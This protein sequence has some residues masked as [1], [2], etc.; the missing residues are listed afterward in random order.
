MRRRNRKN[1]RRGNVVIPD[2]LTGIRDRADH[3]SS[4]HR[5]RVIVGIKI[6]LAALVIYAFATGPAGFLRLFG[7]YREGQKLHAEDR[8]LT[9]E[10]VQLQNIRRYLELDTTYIEKVAREDYGFSRPDEIIY[11][12]PQAEED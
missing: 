10:I 4:S 7:L 6:A 1:R 5:R 9:A 2:L 11:R 12:E 3:F 8:R